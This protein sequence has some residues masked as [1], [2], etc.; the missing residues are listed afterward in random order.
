M[1]DPDHEGFRMSHPSLPGHV[2]ALDD[3]RQRGKV[4]SPPEVMRLVLCATLAGAV[5]FVE[6][7]DRSR[8]AARRLWPFAQGIPSHGRLNDVAKA[9]GGPS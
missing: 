1:R 6:T 4:V 7:R 5:E 8:T 2:S 3:P 9:L